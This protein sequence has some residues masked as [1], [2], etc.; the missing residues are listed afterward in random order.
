MYQR[1]AL[2]DHLTSNDSEHRDAGKVHGHGSSRLDGVSTNVYC[3]DT[4]F[5]F[6]DCHYGSK[7]G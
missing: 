7:L 2:L 3:L 1:N 6:A 5:L 4:K